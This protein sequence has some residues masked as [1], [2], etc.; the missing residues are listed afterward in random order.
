[1]AWPECKLVDLIYFLKWLIKLII[2]IHIVTNILNLIPINIKYKA[3][4]FRVLA[5][6]ILKLISCNI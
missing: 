3:N 4:Y 2:S 6:G 1:M 5:W